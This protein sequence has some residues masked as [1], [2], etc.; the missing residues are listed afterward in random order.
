MRR[1]ILAGDVGGT[2]ARLALFS[3]KEGR[4]RLETLEVFPSRRHADLEQILD[5]FAARH[6][7]K[8]AAACLGIAGPVRDNRVIASNLP[9]VV[10]ASGL[11]RRLGLK[12]VALINDL[13]ANAH[14]LEELGPRSLASLQRGAAGAA[15]NRALVS[16]GTGLGEAMVPRLGGAHVPVASEGGHADFAPRNELEIEL[17]RYLLADLGGRV[18]Y[19]RVLSGAGLHNIYRFLRDTGRGKEEPWLARALA[20]GDAPAAIS[21]AGLE[22]RSLLCARALDL[23]VSLYAAEAGNAALR[24]MAAGGLYLGGGIA[25]K[26]LPKLREPAFMRSFLDKG[27]LRPFLERVPVRVILDDH[28]ALLGAARFAFSLL[29]RKTPAA[30]A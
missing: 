12:S 7:A 8:A 9:W 21:R 20:D 2:N 23:F 10:S 30:A 16:V 1:L 11:A 27:R 15:G 5:L 19:E 17:L 14:G 6:P 4:P 13:E 25:P 18:S 28:T 24:F 26:I 29:Q 22:G 3:W